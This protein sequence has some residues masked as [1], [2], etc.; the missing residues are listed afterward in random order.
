MRAMIQAFAERPAVQPTD[1]AL[2][3]ALDSADGAGR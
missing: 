3:V 1:K 2:T